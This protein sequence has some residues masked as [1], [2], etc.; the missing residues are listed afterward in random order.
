MTG[1]LH[2][3]HRLVNCSYVFKMKYCINHCHA[4]LKRGSDYAHKVKEGSAAEYQMA[5]EIMQI[6]TMRSVRCTP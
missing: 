5:S 4:E 1:K 2:M 6:Y 3:N